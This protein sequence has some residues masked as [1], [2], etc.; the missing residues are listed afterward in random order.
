MLEYL[1]SD[2]SP[3]RFRKEFLNFLAA[4]QWLW[5]G[6]MLSGLSVFVEEKRRRGE[7][8]MYVLPKGLESVW[9][10]ARGRGLIFGMGRYGEALVRLHYRE[11]FC[12]S[13]LIYPRWVV[14]LRSRDG[15]GDEHVSGERC[16]LIS[17]VVTP[18][19][20]KY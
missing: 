13:L 20:L 6:G 16:L 2:R 14:A 3:V 7:L 11:T 15:Y 8:A 9:A 5:I 10:T 18:T 1:S 12:V 17:F 4:K 19:C